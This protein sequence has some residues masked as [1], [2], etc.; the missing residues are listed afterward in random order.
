MQDKP[1]F[2]DAL[3]HHG[4]NDTDHNT[5]NTPAPTTTPTNTTQPAGPRNVGGIIAGS[6]RLE[7]RVT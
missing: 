2:F 6:T 4:G 3:D 5:T 7:G 1:G